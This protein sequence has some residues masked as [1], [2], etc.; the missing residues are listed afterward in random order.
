MTWQFSKTRCIMSM[1]SSDLYSNPHTQRKKWGELEKNNVLINFLQSFTSCL[2]RIHLFIWWQLCVGNITKQ[3]LENNSI[4]KSIT[5]VSRE[6][7]NMKMT[8]A[9]SHVKM[10]TYFSMKRDCKWKEWK[11][12]TTVLVALDKSLLSLK[13]RENKSFPQTYSADKG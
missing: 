7:K 8:P 4:L 10:K 12:R 11:F 9:S 1:P 5:I 13:L 6:D 3:E 2:L